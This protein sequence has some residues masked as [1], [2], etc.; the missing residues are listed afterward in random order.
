MKRL[1]KAI[2]VTKP[3]DGIGIGISYQHSDPRVAQA[4]AALLVTKLQEDNAKRREGLIETTTEFLSVELDRV[5]E[6]LGAKEQAI[7]EFK[8]AHIGE[9]P[10][11]MEANLRTLDRLQTDLTISSE[12]LNKAGERLTALEKAIKEF[13]DPESTDE[14]PIEKSER[15]GSTKPLSRP[16]SD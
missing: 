9:L 15:M 1:R 11:Q 8:K 4:V 6:E 7:S 10:G 14:V 13:S 12:S 2:T 3:K 5:K 16:A